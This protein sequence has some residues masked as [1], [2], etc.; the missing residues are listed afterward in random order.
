MRF[1]FKG[2]CLALLLVP[3]AALAQGVMYG[4]SGMARGQAGIARL[5][6]LTTKLKAD[7]TAKD[8]ELETAIEAIAD[9]VKAISDCG[10]Q[11]RL[12]G[13]G[14]AKA[15][16]NGCIESLTV[17]ADGNI[18][19]KADVIAEGDMQATD[20]SLGG[21]ATIV[22]DVDVGGKVDAAGGVKVGTASEC[23]ADTAGTI[24][25]L[26][27][28]QTLEFCDGA[29]WVSLR[30]SFGWYT[31]N[32]TGCST[33]CGA[34]TQSR[35]VECRNTGGLG[36]EGSYCSDTPPSTSQAC[37]EVSGCS[38]SWT[39]SDWGSCDASPS[40]ASFG[41]Y[42]SCS[43]SCGGGQKCRYRSCQNN[44]G[45]Q[46]RTAQCRRSDGT[47][48]ANSYCSGTPLTS[49]SCT[50][51]CSGSN[52]QCSSCNTQSC[53]SS[54]F[55]RLFY[56]DGS[57]VKNCPAGYAEQARVREQNPQYYQTCIQNGGWVIRLDCYKRC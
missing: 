55:K 4:S 13:D 39:Y 42:G 52:S 26:A 22:G 24:R 9:D 37:T 2:V 23:G 32:W 20:L 25:Y 30:P 27:V 35:S 10:D 49:R 16:G 46:T 34:G 14:H 40:W 11:G 31:S 18:V 36:V 44:G 57:P 15:N 54:D 17:D 43:R 19:G 3:A 21:N 12:Y 50:A 6:A 41:S 8:A 7:L 47:T 48:V 28:D 1:A 51:A 56:C 45:T 29:G 53:C 38:F 5:Q 33:A